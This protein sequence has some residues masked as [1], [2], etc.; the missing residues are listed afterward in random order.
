MKTKK[1]KRYQLGESRLAYLMVAPAVILIIAIAL[2]PVL[3]SFYYSLFDFRLNNPTRND[4]YINY[5]IN[6]EDYFGNYDLG[7]Y[8]LKQAAQSADNSNDPN[9]QKINDSLTKLESINSVIT[10]QKNVSTNIAAVRKYTDNSKPVTDKNLKYITLDKDTALKTSSELLSL[11]NTLKHMQAGKQEKNNIDKAEGIVEVL[12]DSII[13]PNFVGLS[14]YKYYFQ[15]SSF[16]SAIGYTFFFTVISV[17]FELVLGLMVAVIINREFMGRG[18]VRTVVL[19]PWAIPTVVT[20]LMWKFLYDGQSGYMAHVFASLHLVKNSG[21]L[22]TTHSGAT[23]AI[24]F[25]DVW[26]TVPYMA[27]LIL[28]GLQGIDGALYEAAS[29]DGAS[30]VRQFFKI[31]LP[32]LKPTIL[33]ALLF[34]TLDAFRIFDLVYVLT[35]GANNTET[36]STF[37]YKT[38]F[39]QMEFGKGSTL[40]V[41]VFICVMLISIA[42]I[43]VLGA[44]VMTDKK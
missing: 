11:E 15:N 19:I 34:R 14:N 3:K 7:D 24:I 33:V 10:R 26:K 40:S 20:A 42:Y 4:L 38:M 13:T 41:I 8:A 5:K 28:A 21:I 23:F 18:I 30:K 43:K 36:I 1:N 37:A 35:N 12:H 9:A 32:L 17:I 27:L 39:S 44:D 2:Y 29:V 16:Y 22:L 31:T 25:A 6:M